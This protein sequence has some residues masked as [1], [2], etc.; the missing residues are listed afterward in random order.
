[1]AGFQRRGGGGGIWTTAGMITC[2]RRDSGAWT[3]IG[4]IRRRNSTNTG[5]DTVWSAYTPMNATADNVD[6]G[7]S[8]S[9]G[10]FVIGS[11]RC[12]VTGGSSSKSY[13]WARVSGTAFTVDGG[14]TAYATFS[15]TAVA[16]GIQS[17][18]YRCTVSDGTSSTYVDITVTFTVS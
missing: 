16:A 1:M 10:T 18:V 15:V 12:T 8:S 7:R 3:D 5:W 11:S 6:G 2:K 13:A 14:T 9:I 17:A 4:N